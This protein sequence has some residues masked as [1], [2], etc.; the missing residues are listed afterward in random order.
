MTACLATGAV[1]AVVLLVLALIRR[2]RSRSSIN[3][4]LTYDSLLLLCEGPRGW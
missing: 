2:V 4:L 1:L 3:Y